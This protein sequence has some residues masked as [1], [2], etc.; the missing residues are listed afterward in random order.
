MLATNKQRELFKTDKPP[1]TMKMRAKDARRI[2][3]PVP[4][5]FAQNK[6]LV[7]YV[8]KLADRERS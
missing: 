1:R 4:N 3:L 8:P 7:Y 5:G 2:G 6:M